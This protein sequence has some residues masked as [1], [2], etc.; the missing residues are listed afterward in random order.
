MLPCKK[1]RTTLTE[2]PQHQGNQEEDDLDLQAAGKPESDLGSVKDLG[3]VSL[4]WSPSHGR[5]A[6]L[7]V[8]AAGIQLGME[9]PSLSSRMLTEDTNVAV[10]EAVDVAISQEI[11]LA[12]LES[13]QPVNTHIGKGKLQATSSRR[14]KKI[15]LRP[16]SVTQ[17]DR[18]DH[19]I[20]KEPFSEEPS[21]EVKAEGGKSQMHS[22][23]EM[24]SLPSDSHS[25]KP[26]APPRKSSQPDVCASPQEKPLRTLAHQA[27]EETEDGGLFIP[28]GR[29]S[30][31]LVKKPLSLLNYNRQ[32]T[33]NIP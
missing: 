2:S 27:E 31:L 15:T 28:M 9:D 19:P 16:G 26:A 25:A 30:F 12:S 4:S 3:S 23:G 21:E 11:T 32:K 7:E 29:L 14:G 8:Q 18:G 1:R 33:A 24:P 22:G 6:D 17:E 20:A 13:S 10:L 5:A